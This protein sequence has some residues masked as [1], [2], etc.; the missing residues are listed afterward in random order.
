MKNMSI[1]LLI[2]RN[3]ARLEKLIRED[4]SYNKILAQSKRLDKYVAIKMREQLKITCF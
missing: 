3:K 1:E 4:A 2:F